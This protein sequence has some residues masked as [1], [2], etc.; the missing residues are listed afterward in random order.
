MYVK[1][2]TIVEHKDSEE[3]AER[4][5][6]DIDNNISHEEK[7]I[8]QCSPVHNV[9]SDGNRKKSILVSNKHKIR[10]IEE[11]I[12]IGV[13]EVMRDGIRKSIGGGVYR[14]DLSIQYIYPHNNIR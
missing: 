10:Y 7:L 3:D 1:Y 9:S 5:G 6:L 8:K 14:Y 13:N 2:N 4:D 12:I 11:M